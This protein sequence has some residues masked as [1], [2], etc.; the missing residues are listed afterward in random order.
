M[1]L[2]KEEFDCA[3]LD[4]EYDCGCGDDGISSLQNIDQQHGDEPSGRL[5]EKGG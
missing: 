5:P 1:R 2:K 4:A 3:H